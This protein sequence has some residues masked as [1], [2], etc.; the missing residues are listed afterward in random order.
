[1][2]L[3]QL[4]YQL[5]DF[6][7]PQSCFLCGDNSSDCLCSGCLAELPYHNSL[8]RIPC[9]KA[10][11]SSQFIEIHSVFTYTYPLDKLIIAAKFH[12]NLAVLNLLGI[13]MAEHLTIENRPDVLIPVPLHSKR[14]RQRGYNQSLELAKRITKK[15]GIPLAYK[16]CKRIK[17]TLPQT[18]LSA[19]QRQSNIVD[20][21][22]VLELKK[23]WQ[24]V[25]LIDDVM[26]TGA[27]VKELAKVFL[28]MGVQ[29]V[30]VWTCA[31]R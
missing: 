1:M 18:S 2:N 25:V 14:L 26:T 13:L 10:N 17:D 22:Q 19:Q 8:K 3:K 16:S 7:V 21:F 28:K 20:A 5:I 27:T 15:T 29:R 6:I 30:D 9:T 11:K 24:Y 12:Q 4:T 23:Q 31:S